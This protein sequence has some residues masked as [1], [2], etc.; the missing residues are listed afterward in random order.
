MVL[1]KPGKADYSI[2][3]SHHPV[4]LYNMM[5]KLLTAIIA[6]NMVYMAEKFHLLLSNHFGGRPGRMTMDLLH[7]VIN[8]IK[9]AWRCKKVTIMLF[10]DIEGAFSH[11]I[12]A[13]LL[14][15]LQ[16]WQI[17]EEYIHFMERMLTN[18]CT[19]LKF[20]GYLSDWMSINNGI[21]Q[22]DPLS[23]ILYLFY[24]ADHVDVGLEKGQ[25][26]VAFVDDANLYV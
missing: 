19:Q 8:K 22:G 20:D 3:K 2:P 7:L 18:Q 12:T 1:Q 21:G 6:E 26:A 4:A 9:G 15:N 17:P 23:M 24:N 10:L 11:T 16:K 5:G 14:H 13:Q 25:A